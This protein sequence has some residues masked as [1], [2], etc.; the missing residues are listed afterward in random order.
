MARSSA[1]APVSAD[2]ERRLKGLVA[3]LERWNPTV[4]LVSRSTLAE[5]WSRHVLDSLQLLAL[6][7]T[8]ARHWV[9]L[10][11]GGGFP[12]LVIAIAA[13]ESHPALRVTLVESDQ[14]KATFLRETART[15]GCDVKVVAVRI[16]GLAPLEADVVS[17]RAL[18][19]LPQLWAYAERHLA[20]EGVG[21]F[22]K[23]EGHGTEISEARARFSLHIETLPSSVDG[24]GVVLRVRRV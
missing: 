8:G 14:R 16:E 12:G 22:L 13:M 20:P 2:T 4:N 5:A 10:G 19:P 15:L 18:A 24:G 6:A 9:D 1:G 11:S 23:G 21:L 3:A 7:P 17:A